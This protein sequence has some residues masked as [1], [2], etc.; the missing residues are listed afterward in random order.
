MANLRYIEAGTKSRWVGFGIV[1][2]AFRKVIV[3][4]GLILSGWLVFGYDNAIAGIVT[5]IVTLKLNHSPISPRRVDAVEIG[6]K[7]ESFVIDLLDELIDKNSYIASNVLVPNPE[8]VTGTTEIDVMVISPNGIYCVEVKNY[9]GQV[10]TRTEA[11][12][13]DVLRNGEVI[14]MRDPCR[15]VTS[16]KLALESYLRYAGININVGVA[17]LFPGNNVKVQ[18][19]TFRNIPVFRTPAEVAYLISSS[20]VQPGYSQQEVI[21]AL[22]KVLR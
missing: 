18:G 19:R 4:L 14:Q 12:G 13:W 1:E 15:Q 11:G 6:A 9:S 8:S 5:L 22:S 16:Q 17:V 3:M 21:S 10:F 20:L 2:S 7:G